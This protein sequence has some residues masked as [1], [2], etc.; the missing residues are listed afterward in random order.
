MPGQ[1]GRTRARPGVGR[2]PGQPLAGSV[3]RSRGKAALL[4]A[5][6]T[7]RG[8]RLLANEDNPTGQARRGCHASD[9]RRRRRGRRNPAALDGEHLRPG[10]GR[11]TAHR[12]GALR[13]RPE[14][15]WRR[16][17]DLRDLVP[18]QQALLRGALDSVRPGGVVLYATCSPAIEETA[19]VVESVLA[20]RPDTRLE[21][22][23]ALVPEA[24]D[25][26]SA[27]LRGAVQLW[28]HRHGTDAMFMALLRRLGALATLGFTHH[29]YPD[30]AEHP[31]RRPV[32]PR[33]RGRRGSRAPTGCTLT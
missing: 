24:T 16:P 14:S 26:E 21:D 29:G 33:R 23:L 17:G 22:T 2:R 32:P 25:S 10:A 5:L 3:R 27:H 4:G 6:A 12:S 18:L 1:A 31:Q 7:E 28:P 20:D 9:L 13:R 19:G 30:H 11:R 8:A 15:R